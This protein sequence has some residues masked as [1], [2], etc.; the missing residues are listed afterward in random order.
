M[1]QI[2][3]NNPELFN[4]IQSSSKSELIKYLT[5]NPNLASSILSDIASL[6][7]PAKKIKQEAIDKMFDEQDY[8][9][10]IT[11][12][13]K[14]LE[15]KDKINERF[16]YSLRSECNIELLNYTNA[17][18]DINSAIQSLKQNDADDYYQFSKFLKD[19]SEIKKLLNDPFGANQDVLLSKEFEKK[20]E[21]SNPEYDEND[22]LPF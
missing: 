18:T 13:N 2:F 9:G 8:V 5:N 11:I 17:L 10:A 7:E 19:R 22:D 6:D 4:I 20:D 3:Q 12:I 14:G 21:E 16:L 1:E 15:L